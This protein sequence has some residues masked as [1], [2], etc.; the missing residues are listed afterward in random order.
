MAREWA[1]R[2]RPLSRSREPG[3]SHVRGGEAAPLPPPPPSGLARGRRGRPSRQRPLH[4]GFGAGSELQRRRG[5]PRARAEPSPQLCL[6]APGR[7]P[8]PRPGC[9]SDPR[10]LD[11]WGWTWLPQV[12]PARDGLGARPGPAASVSAGPG[13]ACLLSLWP[14]CEVGIMAGLAGL[15]MSAS[16][17]DPHA[18]SALSLLVLTLPD[19]P[20]LCKSVTFG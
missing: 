6:A 3:R 11:V 8:S 5:F 1:P 4:L 20:L 7:S 2:A 14:L 16:P 13:A 15:R 17:W 10:I 9:G 18:A 19:F 12:R